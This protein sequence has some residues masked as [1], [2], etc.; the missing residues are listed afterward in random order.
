M[1]QNRNPPPICRPLPATS[2]MVLARRDVGRAPATPSAAREPRSRSQP[3]HHAGVVRDGEHGEVRDPRGLAVGQAHRDAAGGSG[4]RQQRPG[5]PRAT[6]ACGS[7]GPGRSRPS[8][9]GPSRTRSRRRR[10]GARPGPSGETPIRS[11]A[12]RIRQRS[13]MSSPDRNASSKPMRRISLAVAQGRHQTEPVPAP[14][15]AVVVGQRAAPVAGPA[16]ALEAGLQG[17]VAA[18]VVLPSSWS[19]APVGEHHVGVHQQHPRR[20]CR[21]DAERAGEGQP[22][23]LVADDG[24]AVPLGHLARAVGGPPVDDDDLPRRRTRA[25]SPG[26]PAAAPRRCGRGRRR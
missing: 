7:S 3:P 26:T 9:T 14:A 15:G 8:R 18:G 16:H 13:S 4:G 19:S 20:A 17:V 1:T 22:P 2:P 25:A 10:T 5:V 11:P 6:R 21:R 23:A 24:G 12:S